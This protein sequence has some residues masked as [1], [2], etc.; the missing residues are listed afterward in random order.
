MKKKIHQSVDSNIPH[1]R[2]LNIHELSQTAA[3]KHLAQ[4]YIQLEKK[5]I[6]LSETVQKL[7]KE[8]EVTG[9]RHDYSGT[10]RRV[11]SAQ[12]DSL[13]VTTVQS[14]VADVEHRHSRCARLLRYV[15]RD[16][17]KHARHRNHR[18]RPIGR[19]V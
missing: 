10:Q 3:E 13:R 8:I 4:S 12:K 11:G 18:Y 6:S 7:L 16:H 5:A 19:S 1:D 15:C 17:W 2:P 14:E 9:S